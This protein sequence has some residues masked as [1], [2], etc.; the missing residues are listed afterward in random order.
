MRVL[1]VKTSSLGD[2]VHTLPA[3]TDASRARPGV[4]FDW[5]A[6]RPFAQIPAWHPSVDRVIES[7]LRRWRRAPLATL[8]GPAWRE[9]RASL[10]EVVY[11][12]VLDAQG[13]VKS[14]LL[15]AQ[16]IGPRAGLD[17]SSAREPLAALFYQRRLRV[18]RDRHAVERV[19]ALFA[20]ALDYAQPASAADYG[21]ERARFAA[22]E[23]PQPYLV[24]LHATTWPTKCWPEAS[25]QALGAWARDRGFAV[26]LPW[27]T[28]AERGA[29]ERIAAAFGGTV[30]PRMDLSGVAGVL[31]HARAVVGVDT[32]LAHVAA[33][34][35]TPSITLYGPTLPG[36]TGTVG[37]GQVHLRSTDAASV[38][39]AR[40]TT[41]A[42][43]RV[44]DALAQMLPTP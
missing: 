19:R 35:G 3:L 29:A 1:I 2:L 10:R 15:A 43:E 5:L 17:F 25:W 21:I 6:E 42:V 28:D 26:A 27:G 40:P 12:L 30:L 16:A 24:F 9:F 14:A 32:G 38:D 23:L 31:A 44:I 39:R 18:A 11:D 41:V 8:R 4:R 37:A 36:R 34:V 22:P 7:D 13:L 33:A 20:Q